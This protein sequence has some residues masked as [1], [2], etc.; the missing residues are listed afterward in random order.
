MSG[1]TEQVLSNGHS[2]DSPAEVGNSATPP[3]EAEVETI[4]ESIRE[5]SSRPTSPSP[6]TAELTTTTTTTEFDEGAYWDFPS[7]APLN[8]VSAVSIRAART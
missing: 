5:A 1:A 7:M 2:L 3:T 4:I 6:T 8:A